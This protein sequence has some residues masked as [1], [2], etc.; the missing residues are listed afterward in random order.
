MNID[1]LTKMANQIGGFFEG[2]PDPAQASTDLVKH[3]RNS[4]EPRMREALIA[5]LD[6]K[7][8]EGLSDFVRQ[9]VAAHRQLLH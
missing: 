3:I 9:A 8:G 6:Q 7:Q 1:Y 4:W 5:H 2:Q